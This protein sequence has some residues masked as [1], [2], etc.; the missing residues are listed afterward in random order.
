MV[1]TKAMYRSLRNSW[2][3][4]IHVTSNPR[5]HMYYLYGGR[6]IGM[7]EA[8]KSSFE[9][10][11]LDMGMR[12][13]K[14]RLDRRDKNGDFCK[15][16]CRWSTSKAQARNTRKS[17]RVDFQG[18]TD[19]D[20][21]PITITELAEITGKNVMT[22]K[23]RTCHRKK[24][25]SLEEAVSRELEN[26]QTLTYKGETLKVS[27]WAQRVGLHPAT[28]NGRLRHGWSIEEALT[29]PAMEQDG[30]VTYQGRTQS[31]GEWCKELNIPYNRTHHRLTK[32]NWQVED[33]FTR[34]VFWRPCK[35]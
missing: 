18:L 14:H 30:Q 9:Q 33:A 35:R 31:L 5:Y 24:Q 7:S 3:F 28:I 13:P 11:V 2:S 19:S 8:W 20:G 16:N 23:S 25:L 17:V 26:K 22:L 29:V 4:M 10:F 12:P 27:A 15:D 32:Y 21:K 6:G 34:P 1:L